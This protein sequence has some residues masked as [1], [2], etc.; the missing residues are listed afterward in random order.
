MYINAGHFGLPCSPFQA[1]LQWPRA[2]IAGNEA[3]SRGETLIY[4]NREC[5]RPVAA[6]QTD[7]YAMI[8]SR[9]R[10][11]TPI[12]RKAAISSQAVNIAAPCL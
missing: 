4:I 6:D 12:A 5:Y 9:T 10:I 7:G 11:R 8:A 3:R 1:G 2:L